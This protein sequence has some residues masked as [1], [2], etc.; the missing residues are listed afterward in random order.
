M[1]SPWPEGT[2]QHWPVPRAIPLPLSPGFPRYGGASL[3]LP[4]PF[5]G[6]TVVLVASESSPPPNPVAEWYVACAPCGCKG[7]VATTPADAVWFWNQRAA[8]N[9]RGQG[10]TFQA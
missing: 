10:A 7:P 6:S 1:P 3:L 2:P 4:C 9:G 8:H 5:C